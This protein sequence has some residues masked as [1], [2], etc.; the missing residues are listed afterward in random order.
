MLGEVLY[1]IVY[2]QMLCDDNVGDALFSAC[3]LEKQDFS[4]S[5]ALL[6]REER[7]K[8]TLLSGS[9]DLSYLRTNQTR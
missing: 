1:V 6:L 7:R 8:S 9:I 3:I 2:M 5:S 4:M